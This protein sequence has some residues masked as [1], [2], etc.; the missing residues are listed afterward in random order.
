LGYEQ[1]KVL[2]R[3]PRRRR[4]TDATARRA[5]WPAFKLPIASITAK[6]VQRRKI[7]YPFSSSNIPACC[8]APL[9][10]EPNNN[11]AIVNGRFDRAALI[12]KITIE[13]LESLFPPR[14]S[15]LEQRTSEDCVHAFPRTFHD[16]ADFLAAVRVTVMQSEFESHD[17]STREGER[18]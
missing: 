18:R 16:S 11:S 5:G 13:T 14:V 17:G 6:V 10:R 15:Q 1:F 3:R 2:A 12:A 7:A 9:D 4:E 8:R